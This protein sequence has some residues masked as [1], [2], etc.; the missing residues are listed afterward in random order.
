[1]I[2]TL[3]ESRLRS[4]IRQVLIE[5]GGGTAYGRNYHTLDNNP[6]SWQD[7]PGIDIEYYASADGGY[8]AQV[9][10]TV[11]DSLSTPLR[12]F[13]TEDDAVHF[14][15]YH[16]DKIKRELMSRDDVPAN[17]INIVTIDSANYESDIPSPE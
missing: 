13:A 1:M 8:Y 6:I 10:C 2:I 15:R 9:T 7:Y 3:R 16:T 4:L 11:D 12:L 17:A 14:A 5:Q